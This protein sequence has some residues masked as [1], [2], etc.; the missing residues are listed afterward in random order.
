M[1]FDKT[2]ENIER[3]KGVEMQKKWFVYIACCRDGLYYTGITND[4]SKRLEKHNSGKGALFTAKRRPV[5]I[6][7]TEEHPDKSSA[8]KR[9]IQIKDWR[10]DK[11][12]WIASRLGSK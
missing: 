6:I 8:R 3:P 4:L 7:Y 11:K 5:K 9:E 10:R 1:Q 12:E 2:S